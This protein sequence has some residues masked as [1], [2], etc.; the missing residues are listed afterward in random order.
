MAGMMGSPSPSSRVQRRPLPGKQGWVSLSSLCQPRRLGRRSPT[1]LLLNSSFVWDFS[2][3]LEPVLRPPS[4]GDSAGESSRSGHRSSPIGT[5][6]KERHRPEMPCPGKRVF[7]HLLMRLCSRPKPVL[8]LPETPPARAI[9]NRQ[10]A[11][12][13]NE[14]PPC[15][16]E[17]FSASG[18]GP[19]LRDRSTCASAAAAEQGHAGRGVAR[20]PPA[21]TLGRTAAGGRR[22]FPGMAGI[23]KLAD[24][25]L[26][27]CARSAAACGAAPERVVPPAAS[28]PTPDSASG[29]GP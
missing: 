20:K 24:N 14:R 27:G 5:L 7:Q 29:Q 6:R 17:T 25:R 12:R 23:S 15:M 3:G 28:P 19:G 4:F 26:G 2:A 9:E 1:G 8:C 11:G 18:T 16:A 10:D 22:R 21:R 13:A